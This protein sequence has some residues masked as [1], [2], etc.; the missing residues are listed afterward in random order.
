MFVFHIMYNAILV[1]KNS[2]FT[3]TTVLDNA[4]NYSIEMFLVLTGKYFI[5]DILK[6]VNYFS[7]QFSTQQHIKKQKLS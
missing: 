1:H 4:I 2:Q 3:G 7:E 5:H 6:D